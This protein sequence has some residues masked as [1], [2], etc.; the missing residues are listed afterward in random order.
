M[1]KIPQK[2]ELKKVAS[3]PALIPLK[4]SKSKPIIIRPLSPLCRKPYKLNAAGYQEEPRQPY[5]GFVVHSSQ[6]KYIEFGQTLYDSFLESLRRCGWLLSER[7]DPGDSV[8]GGEWEIKWSKIH[9]S[10]K[11]HFLGE[12]E[13]SKSHRKLIKDFLKYNPQPFH[14]FNGGS[15][16]RW[17]D[18]QIVRPALART[19]NL[20][21]V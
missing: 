14:G 8:H 7:Y 4:F 11:A 6:I 18:N 20:I 2:H 3:P 19:E 9:K 1:L 13:I 17:W 5:V 21:P 15:N 10:F 12:K 16:S